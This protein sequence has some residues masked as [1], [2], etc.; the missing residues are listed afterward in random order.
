MKYESNWKKGSAAAA[1]LLAR[2]GVVTSLAVALSATSAAAQ[3]TGYTVWFT[4]G[5]TYCGV[6]SGTPTWLPT[7]N[8][9]SPSGYGFF[10][11]N[12]RWVYGLLPTYC[13]LPGTSTTGPTGGPSPDLFVESGVGGDGGG[14]GT[15]GTGGDPD[16]GT[17]DDPPGDGTFNPTSL[18]TPVNTLTVTPE[19]S[20]M[21]LLGS[22]LLGLGAAVRRRRVRTQRPQ[23]G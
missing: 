16:T 21:L 10:L 3:S 23:D 9:I 1:R 8:G 20:T 13:P 18:D 6:I 7:F 4:N 11:V 15:G 22:G 2:G 19:P 12:G 5:A 14:G 17:N